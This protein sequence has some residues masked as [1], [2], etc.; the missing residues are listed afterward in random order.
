LECSGT[1]ISLENKIEV[2]ERDITEIL[3]ETDFGAYTEAMD[4]IQGR[5]EI[6][7]TT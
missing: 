1:Q 2:I 4:A 6:F 5:G 3:S 7:N